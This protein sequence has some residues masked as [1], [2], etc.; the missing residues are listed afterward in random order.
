MVGVV[1]SFVISE[2]SRQIAVLKIFRHDGGGEKQVVRLIILVEPEGNAG[3]TVEDP[4]DLIALHLALGNR[5]E[6]LQVHRVIKASVVAPIEVPKA[7]VEMVSHRQTFGF[8][9]I[10][11]DCADTGSLFVVHTIRPA[12]IHQIRFPSTLP[13]LCQGTDI[14]G[15]NGS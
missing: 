6:A 3:V 14:L 15:G 11:R 2:I 12:A 9:K 1:R 5:A 8:G 13:D 4:H 7:H 10:F